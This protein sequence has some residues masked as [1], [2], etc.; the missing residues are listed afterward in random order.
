MPAS[1]RYDMGSIT[2]LV[3]TSSTRATSDILART[4]S[5]EHARDWAQH[6]AP[7]YGASTITIVNRY[8]GD[9]LQWRKS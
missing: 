9:S 8:T 2:F 5:Y 6:Y 4:R 3:I 7:I 1:L